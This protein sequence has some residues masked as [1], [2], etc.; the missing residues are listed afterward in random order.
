M[1][2]KVQISIC[3]SCGSDRIT[4]VQQD[5][6]GKVGKQ[7]YTVPS[8]EFYECPDCGESF[9][10]EDETEPAPTGD[11]VSKPDSEGEPAEP[12]EKEPEPASAGDDSAEPE[13]DED[14]EDEV[15]MYECPGCGAMVAESDSKCPECGAE[16]E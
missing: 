13:N 16:F 3:P 5:W 8:L 10:D 14:S 12:W 15:V 6:T 7:V 1:R 11:D 2:E 9:V 4:K